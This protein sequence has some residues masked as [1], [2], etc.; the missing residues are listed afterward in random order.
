LHNPQ[1]RLRA[2]QFAQVDVILPRLHPVV[3]IPAT[4]LVSEAY[5]DSVFVIEE[6]DGKAVARQQFVQ[7]GLRRGDFVEV[8]KGLSPGDRVVS[9]GA[10]KL[11]NGAT[12]APNDAMQPEASETP[13]PKNS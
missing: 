2:G 6:K 3:A 4:A 10:F 1:D 12:V 9:A 8:T 11:T 5:G 7:L 13:Q